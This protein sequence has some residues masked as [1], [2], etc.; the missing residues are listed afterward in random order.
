MTLKEGAT[1]EINSRWPDHRQRNVALINEWYGEKYY[2]NMLVGIQLVR[3]R[4]N[5]LKS[6]GATTWSVTSQFT[7]DLDGLLSET[8]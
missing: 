4:Y 6:S 2:S 5:E 8:I 3:D 1:Q 7:A